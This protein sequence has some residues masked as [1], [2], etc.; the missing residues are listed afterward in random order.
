[1]STAV[2]KAPFL[3]GD[4]QEDLD[5]LDD[6][7][8][9]WRDHQPWL[10]EQGYNLRPRYWPDWVPS[11]RG[12]NK[13]RWNCE[14]S[15]PPRI[16]VTLDAVHI[17]DNIDV[18]LKRIEVD[19]HPFEA[20]IGTF[21]T[22]G[23]LEADSRNHSVPILE[24]LQVPEDDG[25]IIIVMPLLRKYEEPRFE[26][27]GEAVDFFGQIF[28][29]LKFMHDHNVAHRDCNGNNIMM[30]G[31]EM[32]P[33]GY[34][35]QFPKMKR[36]S[37]SRKAKYYTRTQRPPKYYFIDFGLSR[38]YETRDPP[39]RQPPILGGDKSVPEFRFSANGDPPQPCDPFP[40]DVY[41]L[42]NLIRTDFLEGNPIL[43]YENRMY[44]FEFMK[45]LADDM[46]AEDPAQRPTMDEVVERFTM[47]RNGL[48]SWKL[49]SRVVQADY[50][51]NPSRPF[52]H[53]VLRIGYILRRVSAIPTH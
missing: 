1:M 14:D 21:L 52:K 47:I 29:G 41:Y 13:K 37:Y 16:V 18:C 30:D 11:W 7:E 4:S 28:E 53:W 33:K 8:A 50:S 51:L 32:F 19:K 34:H 42:G 6:F 40:T 44:G 25:I 35:P 27:F 15:R 38:R 24:I 22:S 3:A 26:T 2:S 39:P 17:Q 5:A 23:S 45:T 20:E 36:D 48:S 31:S 9:F 12:T 10:K 43:H 46:T 49:R